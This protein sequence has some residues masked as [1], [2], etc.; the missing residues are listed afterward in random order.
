MILL[1]RRMVLGRIPVAMGLMTAV[2]GVMCWMPIVLGWRPKDQR[3]SQIAVGTESM[4]MGT[5]PM[6]WTIRCA[7]FFLQKTGRALA[8]VGMGTITMRTERTERTQHA[9]N[10]GGK[11][12]Q[13]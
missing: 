13:D 10:L 8:P 3:P 1:C 12:I 9:V 2:M 6:I 4:T 7:P 11:V 5:A